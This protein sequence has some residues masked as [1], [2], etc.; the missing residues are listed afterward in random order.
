MFFPKL[1]FNFCT[2]FFVWAYMQALSND[3]DLLN[4]PADVEKRKHKLKR[5]VKTPNSF[6]MVIIFPYFYVFLFF[7]IH[8]FKLFC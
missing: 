3:I 4:P 5:L 6:F 8:F 2:D 7:C 1:Y